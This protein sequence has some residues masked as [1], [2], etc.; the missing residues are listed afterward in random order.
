[1]SG[2]E[3]IVENVVKTLDDHKGVDIVKIDL[4]KIENC[5]CSFFVICHGTSNSHVASLADYVH[6][7]VREELKET[8]IHKEGEDQAQWVVLDYGDVV[9]HIFQKEQRDYYQLEDFWVDAK[10]TRLEE[11]LTINYGRKQ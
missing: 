7:S 10:I 11:N 6:D 1:M 9:V 3:K 8:P 4:R 5:F 2:A